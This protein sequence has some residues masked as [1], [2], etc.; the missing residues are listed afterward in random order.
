MI[1]LQVI[2]TVKR[3]NSYLV[4]IPD[5]ESIILEKILITSNKI[6]RI[7]NYCV[8]NNYSVGELRYEPLQ[9]VIDNPPR[10]FQPETSH[11]RD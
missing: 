5:E 11:Y 10:Y 3:D 6:E 1:S 8:K 9:N 7:S 4:S 2:I